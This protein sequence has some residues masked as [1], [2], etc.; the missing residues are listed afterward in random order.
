MATA[1]I[2]GRLG[3]VGRAGA[4]VRLDIYHKA[5]EMA[6]RFTKQDFGSRAVWQ[7][8]GIGTKAL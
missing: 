8:S 4:A 2:V 3:I 7:D 1:E 6:G 5:E